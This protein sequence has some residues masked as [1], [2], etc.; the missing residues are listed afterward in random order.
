MAQAYAVLANQDWQVSFFTVER[1]EDRDGHI[2]RAEPRPLPDRLLIT[3]ILKD[4]ANW[5]PEV[6][7]QPKQVNEDRC[8]R[9]VYPGDRCFILD[10]T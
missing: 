1:I 6:A 3:D 2:D 5:S 4:A 7:Y 10:R 8:L 9:Y